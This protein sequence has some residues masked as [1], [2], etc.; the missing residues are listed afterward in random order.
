MHYA[1][2]EVLFESRLYG[3]CAFL[4]L[5]EGKLGLIGQICQQRVKVCSFTDYNLGEESELPVK[6][7]PK[8]LLIEHRFIAFEILQGH[9]LLSCKLLMKSLHP[10]I[11]DEGTD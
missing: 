7:L 10:R 6:H 5:R 4:V 1:A 2:L 3:L 9:Y 8:L 11:P